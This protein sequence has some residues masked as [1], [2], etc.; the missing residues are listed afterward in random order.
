MKQAMKYGGFEEEKCHDLIMWR[1]E[2][3]KCDSPNPIGTCTQE[4]SPPGRCVGQ[5][6]VPDLEHSGQTAHSS[7]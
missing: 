6:G 5:C 2:S 3:E 4:G 1:L 7:S